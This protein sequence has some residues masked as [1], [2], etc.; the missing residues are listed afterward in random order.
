MPKLAALIDGS[1]YW[2]SVCDHASWAAQRIG[3]EVEVM[4]FLGRRDITSVPYDLTGSLSLGTQESLLQELSDLDAKR[5]KLL[6]A[7]G[8][9]L[10]AEAKARMEVSGLAGVATK[11]RHGDLADEVEEL[12]ANLDLIVLGKRGEAADFAQMHLGSNLER[13]IRVSKKP[14][15]VASRAFKPIN[16]FLLAFDGG[17]SASKAVDAIATGS[18]LAGLKCHLVMVGSANAEAENRLRAAASKLQTSRY[19]VIVSMQPG[20]SED[21]IS[22][23]VEREEISLLVMGAYGHSRLR[24]MIIG[25]T[26][27]TMVRTCKIPVLLYR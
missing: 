17:T 16:K 24:N 20:V 12:G 27:T 13:V 3:G 15:M 9:A 6:Q 4:H 25:S 14:V 21:V 7:R 5:A 2:Q 22:A 1:V 10:L 18:L 8:R 19:D 26:T 23:M 11:L